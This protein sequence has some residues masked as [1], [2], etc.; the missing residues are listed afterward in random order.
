MLQ[1]ISDLGLRHKL[2]IE[3][4]EDELYDSYLTYMAHCPLHVCHIHCTGHPDVCPWTYNGTV[5]T[6]VH[7]QIT[8]VPVSESEFHAL[9]SKN[10]ALC[11]LDFK[12]RRGRGINSKLDLP[13]FVHPTPSRSYKEIEALLEKLD[14]LCMVLNA[15]AVGLDIDIRSYENSGLN[16]LIEDFKKAV[17]EE[18]I[19]A[20]IDIESVILVLDALCMDLNALVKSWDT[21][22][23]T[24]T[25]IRNNYFLVENSRLDMLIEDFKKAI[26]EVFKKASIEKDIKEMEALAEGFDSDSDSDIVS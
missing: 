24:D 23:D 21:D 9:K 1:S 15:L 5:Q 7:N 10:K 19:K 2:I 18:F 11:F 25:D 17:I 8:C 12:R 4:S 20:D 26:I 13:V 6:L 3:S 22:T 14:A 16:L